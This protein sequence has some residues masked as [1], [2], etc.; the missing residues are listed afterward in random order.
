MS[1]GLVPFDNTFQFTLP[2]GERPMIGILIVQVK[3]F[4]F[5]LPRGERPFC[6]SFRAYLPVSIH[7]PARG[8]TVYRPR[9]RQTSR[10]FNS[11][12]R[13]GSDLTRRS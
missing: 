12:S 4:Q 8:A 10:S 2:R 1:L 7:A 6:Q 9:G 11:R 3:M 5:T 13:E